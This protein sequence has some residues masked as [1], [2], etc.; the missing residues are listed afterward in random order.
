LLCKNNDCF[1]KNKILHGK[2]T[3]MPF[4]F[5]SSFGMLD[6]LRKKRFFSLNI[7]H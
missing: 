7:E 5:P 2:I 3:N 6:F 4:Y 1:L